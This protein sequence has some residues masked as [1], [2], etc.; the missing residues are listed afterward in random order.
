VERDAWSPAQYERFAAER[1]Q[2]FDDLCALVEPAPGM[3]VIDLGCGTGELTA[4]LHERLAARETLGL[5]RSASMLA[6]SAGRAR[7]GLR[8]AQGDIAELADEARWELV[9]SNAALHWLPD[10]PTLFRRLAAALPPGGQLAVQMPA[11]HDHPSHRI[12]GE[13]ADEEPFAAARGA[14]RQPEPILAPERYASLLDALGFARQHVRLQVYGHHLA[15]PEE[16][17]EWVRGTTLTPY[18]AALPEP[19]FA[20]FVARYRERLLAELPAARPYFYTFKRV[21][22]WARRDAA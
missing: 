16:V 10:H 18:Q 17:V 8:F 11:N 14:A 6:R 1:R 19:L 21:L 12:A 15:G 7:P 9:F 2:P 13:V 22:L 4:A 3:R 20:R 5:E